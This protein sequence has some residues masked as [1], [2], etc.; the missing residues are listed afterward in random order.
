MEM[1]LC[2]VRY[3]LEMYQLVLEVKLAKV[4]SNFYNVLAVSR[5]YTSH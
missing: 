4:S 3:N 1:Y 2:G 5:F